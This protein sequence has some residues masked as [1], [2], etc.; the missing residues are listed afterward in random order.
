MNKGPLSGVK[1]IEFTSAWAGPYATCLLSFL[2]AEVIKVESRRRPD[3]TR[4]VHYVDSSLH[5]TLD[6]SN[7]YNSLNLNKHCISLNLS[8]PKAVGIAKRLVELC[9]VVMENMRPG[10]M[11]RLGLGYEDLRAVKPARSVNI[12]GMPRLSGR[13]PVSAISPVTMT[14]LPAP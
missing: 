3:L 6:E 12:S 13:S 4:L 9:D 10:V 14:G 7:V 8:K 1:I 11:P 2:G 5:G